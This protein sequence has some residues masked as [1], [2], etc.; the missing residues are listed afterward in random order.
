MANVLHEGDDKKARFYIEEN[1]KRIANLEYVY[2]GI[3]K[4]IIEHTEVDP[5]HEGQGLGKELVK[6]AVDFARKN[7]MKIIP[8]CPY[9]NA[10]FK[11]TPEYVDVWWQH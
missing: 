7:N 3:D 1:G 11:R 5:G 6:A 2:A 8:L 4:F 9:A 10:A